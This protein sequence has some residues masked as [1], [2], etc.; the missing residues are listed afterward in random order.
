MG[1]VTSEQ[2][3]SGALAAVDKQSR[4]QGVVDDSV[5]SNSRIFPGQVDGNAVVL[6]KRRGKWRESEIREADLER[7]V[8]RWEGKIR[9][10]DPAREE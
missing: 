7:D 8:R 1:V 3:K 9:K 4:L 5:S 6:G 10:V 2:L